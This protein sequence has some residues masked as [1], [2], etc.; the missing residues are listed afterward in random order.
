MDVSGV[1][2]AT[3]SRPGKSQ[4]SVGH[5]AKAA[6]SEAKSAG[7]ELPK[8]AQ[9]M[10]ASAI[11]KGADPASVFAALLV[12]D[13][14]EPG[15]PGDDVVTDPIGDDVPAPSEEGLVIVTETASDL[16]EETV[17]SETATPEIAITT[18]PDDNGEA[19]TISDIA[20]NSVDDAAVSAAEAALSL[21]EAAAQDDAA[22]LV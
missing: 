3:L 7:I 11:A 14:S 1:S 13:P 19:E 10:A 17:L 16:G 21:L 12:P 5:M 15:E 6:V 8:N 9:G 2:A 22:A 18:S 4:Q 20:L